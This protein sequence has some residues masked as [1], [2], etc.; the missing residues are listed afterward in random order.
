MI[1]IYD[2]FKKDLVESHHI[3]DPGS[4]EPFTIG[5]ITFTIPT[6]LNS[7]TYWSNATIYENGTEIKTSDLIFEIKG[8]EPAKDDGILTQ[9]IHSKDIPIG[10]SVM[11]MGTF[12][13]NS[14]S[15]LYP[16]LITVIKK[17]G[18]VIRKLESDTYK[19]ESNTSGDIIVFFTPD[20]TGEYSLASYVN[21]GYRSTE[22]IFS[23]FKVGL[24]ETNVLGMSDNR[25]DYLKIA[26]IG[27]VIY[28]CSSVVVY[29]FIKFTKRNNAL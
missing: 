2:K 12:E 28:L 4:I 19:V 7:G 25:T 17:D 9:L 15:T 16:I 29:N 23:S 24:S 22:P 13:N 11:I 26:L 27:Y 5:E 14:K 18:E 3:L 21:Y 10:E 1:D 20:L 6:E 8:I